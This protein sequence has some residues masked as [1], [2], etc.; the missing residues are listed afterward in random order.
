MGIIEHQPFFNH[1]FQEKIVSSH[2]PLN[3]G[4]GSD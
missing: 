1:F 4:F 3:L 2:S